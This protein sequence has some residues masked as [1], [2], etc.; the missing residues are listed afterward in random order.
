[1]DLGTAGLLQQPFRT[2][3]KPVLFVHYSGQQAA[4]DFLNSTY[5]NPHGLGL[6]LGPSLSGKTTILRQFVEGLDPEVAVAVIN[7][8]GLSKTALLEAILGQFGYQLDYGSVNEL[9]NMLKVFMM[10]QTAS[11]KTPVIIIEHMHAMNP[12]A[13]RSLCELASIKVRHA[14]ALRM[15]F[16]S[17]RSIQSIIEAPAMECIAARVTGE[18]YLQPLEQAEIAD[19]LYAKLE[20]GGS[21]DPSRLM[22]RDICHELHQASGGWPGIVDRLALLALSRASNCPI[23]KQHIEHPEILDDTGAIRLPDISEEISAD[24]DMDAPP[25]LHLSLN[26]ETIAELELNRPRALIGRSEHND[27]YIDSR[28]ISRHHALFMRHGSTIFLMDLN[29]TNGTYVNSR[30]VSNHVMMHN[31]VIKLG[32]HSIKFEYPPAIAARSVDA[33]DMADTVIMKNLDDMR[34]ML[35]QENTHEMLLDVDDLMSIGDSDR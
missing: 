7:G 18:L 2:H 27:L 10:Q 16:A 6:F 11:G 20:A 33:T 23:E 29:S 5:E 21:Y 22:P 17:D 3:G 13:L 19:Y 26:G 35:A 14:S 9:V 25:R 1:M 12:S 4:L 24:I 34:R 30:K 28:F 15:I 8:E 31:D 32:N